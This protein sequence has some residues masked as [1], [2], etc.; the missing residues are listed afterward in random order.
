[1]G[2][3][4]RITSE[5]RESTI[6]LCRNLD[7]IPCQLTGL[8]IV[9]CT[10]GSTTGC[11]STGTIVQTV[12]ILAYLTPNTVGTHQHVGIGLGTILERYCHATTF[13]QI[14]KLLDTRRDA[15]GTLGETVLYQNLLND[16]PVHND[17]GRQFRLERRTDS[18]EPHE[19]IAR[20]VQSRQ[21]VPLA[22]PN[23]QS[24][25]TISSTGTRGNQLLINL[26]INLLQ[27][28]QCIRL[29]LNRSTIRSIRTRLL[30]QCHLHAL[31]MTRCRNHQTGETT[32]SHEY[33]EWILL[34][35]HSSTLG[36][37]PLRSPPSLCIIVAGE[38]AA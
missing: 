25:N 18:I 34:G 33:R 27:C 21:F 38:H 12:Q 29:N 5:S 3:Q 37:S 1:M 35:N 20:I 22:I 24:T 7:G 28:P 15:N 9:Q 4:G 19:P 31:G 23:L 8:R 2:R 14:L 32:P 16:G 6:G 13:A 36:N 26:G 11:E 10:A 30:K 17:R